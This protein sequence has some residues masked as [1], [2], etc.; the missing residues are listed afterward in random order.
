MVAAGTSVQFVALPQHW[1]KEYARAFRT[2]GKYK[3]AGVEVAG[4]REAADV[5]YKYYGL[6]DWR[7]VLEVG[8]GYHCGG[9]E[10][11]WSYRWVGEAAGGVVG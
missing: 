9:C 6:V 5:V 4:K 10:G 8:V 2:V 11:V 1:F 3:A 7:G